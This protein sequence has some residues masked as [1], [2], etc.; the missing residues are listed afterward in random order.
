MFHNEIEDM[1]CTSLTLFSQGHFAIMYIYMALQIIHMNYC[2]I[3]HDWDMK[4]LT[5]TQVEFN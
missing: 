4:P 1:D 2:L 5:G 3:M